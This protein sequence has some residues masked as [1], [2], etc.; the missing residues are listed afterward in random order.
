MCKE[1]GRFVSLNIFIWQHQWSKGKVGKGTISLLS[2]ALWTLQG[3]T[4]AKVV[5][6]IPRCF[7][8]R[9]FCFL[10]CFCEILS[11]FLLMMKF[12]LASQVMEKR[13]VKGI[14]CANR[15]C[16]SLTIKL[17][18]IWDWFEKRLRRGFKF[19]DAFQR[20]KFLL[21]FAFNVLI[22]EETSSS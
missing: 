6:E 14:I 5:G 17:S 1:A 2:G 4:N 9:K 10:G 20:L 15:P 18:G 22:S 3:E 13:M 21:H 7:V 19:Q 12:F 16:L 8:F 11:C